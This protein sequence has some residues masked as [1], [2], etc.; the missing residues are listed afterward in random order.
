MTKETIIDALD[1]ST[2]LLEVF[3][4]ATK[5]YQGHF[6]LYSFSSGFK[7]VYGTPAMSQKDREILLTLPARMTLMQALKKAITGVS[8]Y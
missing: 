1:L 7:V 3:E 5:H 4:H 8:H 2:A 6:T